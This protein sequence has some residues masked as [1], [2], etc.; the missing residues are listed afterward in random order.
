M[1]EVINTFLIGLVQIVSCTVI[2]QELLE[3]KIKFNINNDDVCN[4]FNVKI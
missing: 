2:V 4:V 3:K 1:L